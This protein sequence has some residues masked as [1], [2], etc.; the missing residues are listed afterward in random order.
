[1]LESGGWDTHARQ[2]AANGSL[3]GKFSV[4][5][6]GIAILQRDMG[7]AWS[8]T[9]VMVV[10]E[11]GRTVKVNGTGGTDHGT[12]TAAML[13][14]GAVNGGRVI[15]DWPGLSPSNLYQGRDL[16]PSTDIRSVFKG[17]LVEHLQLQ[18]NFVDRSV[19]PD[20]K[21]IPMIEKLVRT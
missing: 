2:G 14:G 15:A 1:V 6:N 7:D 11:F 17:V 8:K 16:Y 5:D 12:A 19:F 3:A 4:L 13:V 18:E 21:P 10:T 9:V 20:A